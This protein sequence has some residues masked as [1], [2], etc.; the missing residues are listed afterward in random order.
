MIVCMSMIVCMAMAV[1]VNV[2]VMVAVCYV[3]V[4]KRRFICFPRILE[5]RRFVMRMTV[6]IVV[7]M[8][9]PL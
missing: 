7:G 8:A 1:A 9:M 6:V 4:G 3:S 2:A 5:R